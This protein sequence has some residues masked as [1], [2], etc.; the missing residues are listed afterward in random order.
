MWA[1]FPKV[2]SCRFLFDST[3]GNRGRCCLS[4]E[5]RVVSQHLLYLPFVGPGRPFKGI[6]FS[7]QGPAFVTW[8]RYHLLLLERDLQVSWTAFPFP[9]AASPFCCVTLSSQPR[10]SYF[11]RQIL[12]QT[13]R[14]ICSLILFCLKW[15]RCFQDTADWTVSHCEQWCEGYHGDFFLH[16]PNRGQEMWINSIYQKKIKATPTH[17]T[18]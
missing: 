12:T 2:Q 18:W 4:L 10:V 3:P 17:K 8:H 5:P 13:P 16:L 7:H 11:L 15:N 1:F 6:D 9:H 14:S